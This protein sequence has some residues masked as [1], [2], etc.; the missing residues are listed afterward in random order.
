MRVP[1]AQLYAYLRSAWP[2]RPVRDYF[3]AMPRHGGQ[4]TAVVL[5][6]CTADACY[7]A[8]FGRIVS[9]LRQRAALRVEQAVV[10]SLNV[11][12]GGRL[13]KLLLLRT[14]FNPLVRLKWVRAYR[15]FCDRV[16]Y[17]SISWRPVSDSIDLLRAWHA[18]RQ[19][20]DKDALVGLVIDGVWVGDLVYDSYLRFA[21][22]PTVDLKAKYLLVVLWQAFRDVRRAQR[23]FGRIRPVVYL[24]PY[25][26]YIQHGIAAR[27]ALQSGTRVFAFGNYQEFMKELT[28]ADMTHTRNPD[29]YARDFALLDNQAEKLAQAE[30]ALSARLSG[31]ID[32][33]TAYM[34]QSAYVPTEEAV[35][36]VSGAVVVF[37]HDFYDSPHV[38]REMVFPDFWEWICFTIETLRANGTRFFLKPHPNQISL[39]DAAL[40]DL[41]R[42]Y[43]GLSTIS[44]SV[45][46]KQLVEAG[47][48][49]AVTVYGT[50]AHEMAFMG[51][52]TI[53]CGHHPHISFAFCR[54]AHSREEYAALLRDALAIVVAKALM[55]RESLM[56]YYMHNLNRTDEARALGEAATHLRHACARTKDSGEVISLLEELAKLAGFAAGIGELVSATQEERRVTGKTVGDSIC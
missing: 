38:Y 56:F 28:D 13:A 26:T 33:A 17:R 23:Y 1:G 47:M 11:S 3:A 14:L 37:L 4:A 21:P 40:A 44:P 27:V 53:A 22:A 8:L 46:N 6:Q 30:A 54:T 2:L 20:H 19:L 51:V 10:H 42:T 32:A 36:D 48:A 31:G 39:S 18:W 41:Q 49:C 16:A 34:Q 12:E 5:V 9:S 45:T 35:P 25:S 24:T 43:P 7:F 52:P 55:R 29:N 50:V 15:S